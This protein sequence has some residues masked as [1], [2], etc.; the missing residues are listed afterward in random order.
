MAFEWSRLGPRADGVCLRHLVSRL[1][2][3]SLCNSIR[4]DVDEAMPTNA[5]L[6]DN[7]D[8]MFREMLSVFLDILRGRQLEVLPVPHATHFRLGADWGHSKP[9]LN[10]RKRDGFEIGF[11]H[12]GSRVLYQRLPV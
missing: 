5:A 9:A 11:V 1:F 3:Y 4:I 12:R 10:K 8:I 2:R 7:S 6:S